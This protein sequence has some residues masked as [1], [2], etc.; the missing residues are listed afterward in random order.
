MNTL[1]SIA[2][3]ATSVAAIAF[4]L[5]VLKNKVAANG[6]MEGAKAKF[7]PKPLLTQNELE[8]LQRLEDAVPELR[9][10]PQV[11]MGAILDPDA[12]R[13]D[14]KNYMRLRG[15]FAQKII[16]FVAQNRSTGA[17]VAIIE[18]DDRTH[19]SE[20][21]EK[22]DAM[23]AS[24]GFKIVRWQSNAKPNATAIRAELLLNAIRG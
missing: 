15:M 20:K 12:P 4:G 22:R 17:I 10:C 14:G 9:I 5:A 16:D 18:L 1:S 8:F 7:K 11:A 24:A 19:K 13:S 6:G 2:M 21:D 23:L 3:G